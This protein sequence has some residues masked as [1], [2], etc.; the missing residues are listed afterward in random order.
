MHA[1]RSCM[2]CHVCVAECGTGRVWR[3]PVHWTG[4]PIHSQFILF[5]F[6]D[7]F[8]SMWRSDLCVAVMM[9]TPLCSVHVFTIYFILFPKNVKSA[10]ST[11]TR[12]RSESRFQ[13][14]SIIIMFILWLS[15]IIYDSTHE[16]FTIQI[17]E[18]NIKKQH[19]LFRR[20][21]KGRHRRQASGLS[22]IFRHFAQFIFFRENFLFSDVRFRYYR[23][24][25]LCHLGWINLLSVH[26]C[27]F[28]STNS[29]NSFVPP[30]FN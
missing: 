6:Y 18:W 9:C 11:R 16:V 10:H 22:L 5:H 14:I 29:C 17:M 20:Q 1:S 12:Y 27:F 30:N 26:S 23:E 24:N 15:T 25:K 4:P 21:A 3:A 28:R 19:F 8:T 7:T 13:M 2:S